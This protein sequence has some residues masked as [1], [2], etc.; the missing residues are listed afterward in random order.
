MGTVRIL[1][2]TGLRS[3]LSIC[4]AFTTGLLT[5]GIG[6]LSITA[7]LGTIRIVIGAGRVNIFLLLFTPTVS[8]SCLAQFLIT[9]K[10]AEIFTVVNFIIAGVGNVRSHALAETT[11]LLAV[12]SPFVAVGLCLSGTVSE[13]VVASVGL[14]RRHSFTEAAGIGTTLADPVL[15]AGG[16]CM[17][18]AVTGI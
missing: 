15:V 10:A 11:G 9:I 13:L 7:K 1:V 8:T 16:L 4:S 2:Y 3:R 14:G 12:G 17:G 18:S 5:V 6:N